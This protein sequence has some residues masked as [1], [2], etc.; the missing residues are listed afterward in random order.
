MKHALKKRRAH[1]NH[2]IEGSIIAAGRSLTSARAAATATATNGRRREMGKRRRR[3][4]V[5]VHEYSTV[6]I[7]GQVLQAEQRVIGLGTFTQ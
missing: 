2:L 1:T 5:V 4:L 7:L 3:Q 6:R